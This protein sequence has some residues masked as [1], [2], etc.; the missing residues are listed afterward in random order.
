MS[1]LTPGFPPVTARIGVPLLPPVVIPRCEFLPTRPLLGAWGA[2]PA[3]SHSLELIEE[4]VVVGAQPGAC[5]FLPETHQVLQPFG[6]TQKLF[7]PAG[8]QQGRCGWQQGRGS[9]EPS[10]RA[11]AS[12]PSLLPPVRADKK[13][14]PP[15]S[16]PQAGA[17]DGCAEMVPPE[18]RSAGRSPYCSRTRPR[19]PCN[20]RVRAPPLR[21]PRSPAAR[22]APAQDRRAPGCVRRRRPPYRP[23]QAAGSPIAPTV[24]PSLA[25]S[26]NPASLGV[27]R[28]HTNHVYTTRALSSLPQVPSPRGL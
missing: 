16:L 25:P 10:L 11:P 19:P 14:A 12:F 4:A 22:P 23:R 8:S 20:P 15:R 2:A 26:L 21:G 9:G 1:A 7:G 6:E 18:L 3:A 17:L 27:W 13:K 28:P 24:I 5:R